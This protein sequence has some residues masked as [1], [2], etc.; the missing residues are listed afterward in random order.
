M[1]DIFYLSKM[2]T[3]SLLKKNFIVFLKKKIN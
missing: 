3:W 1:V 2:N